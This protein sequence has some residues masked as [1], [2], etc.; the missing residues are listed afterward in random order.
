MIF[1][2][3]IVSKLFPIVFTLGG[4][5]LGGVGLAYL[6][7]GEIYD[8]Q[9]SVDG[10]HLP[11]VDAVVCLA[12]GRGRIGAAG[13]LW[14][15]YWELSRT[16][17]KEAG[18]VPVPGTPPVFYISGMGPQSNYGVFARQLRRGV[19]EVIHPEQVVL[20]TESTNTESNARWL[21]RYAYAHRWERVLL[22]TSSYH[23][24]RARYLFERV[25]KEM[26]PSPD[27]VVAV[28]TFSVYQ[29][30]FD[31]EEWREGLHGTRVTLTE[32]FKWIYYRYGWGLPKP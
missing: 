23:M 2:R 5:L 8:Y 3:R 22:I 24:K 10:V 16:P 11:Q 20:E 6:L 21:A 18:P 19:K 30:P 29:D 31:P 14:Y 13:D 27:R 15:R 9:D 1:S 4:V 7:A 26:A 28:E 12:G 25:L 32:Y 17:L